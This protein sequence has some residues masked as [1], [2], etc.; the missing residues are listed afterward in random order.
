MKGQYGNPNE[1]L[2][3]IQGQ[4]SPTR[5][6]IVPPPRFGDVC[7]VLW[8]CKTAA[9]VAAIAGRDER[10]A[11]R[12]MAGEFEPPIIVVIAIMAEMFKRE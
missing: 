12:W 1:V 2:R 6:K 4:F 9:H 5:D 8:P 7:K 11:K 10:T 3:E